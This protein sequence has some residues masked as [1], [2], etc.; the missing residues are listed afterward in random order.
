MSQKIFNIGLKYGKNTYYSHIDR[1][2][3]FGKPKKMFSNT[4]NKSGNILIDIKSQDDTNISIKDIPIGSA[5]LP[6]D[7][8]KKLEDD[9]KQLKSDNIKIGVAGIIGM[10]SLSAWYIITS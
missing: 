8:I 6:M 2:L 1:N 9:I 3:L 7:Q 5:S 10:V 4:S